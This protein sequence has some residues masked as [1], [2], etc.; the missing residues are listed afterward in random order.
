LGSSGINFFSVTAY[1]F[2][3]FAHVFM[4]DFDDLVN[5]TLT[6]I[7]NQDLSTNHEIAKHINVSRVVTDYVLDILESRGYIQLVKTLGGTVDV[8]NVS[9]S[10]RRAARNM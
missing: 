5:H 2:E 9:A 8:L 10:G 7:L 3:S 1:G 6:A 4:K